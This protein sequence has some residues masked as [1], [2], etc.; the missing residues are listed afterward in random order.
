MT[1]LRVTAVLSGGGVKAAA[2]LGAVRALVE[3]GLSP[4]RYIG[5]SMGAVMAAALAAG[6]EPAGIFET[7]AGLR[8]RDLARLSAGALVRGV[9]AE[10]LLHPEPL[11]RALEMLVPA[12][13][14][15]ELIH[16]LTV[17]AVD[18]DSGL[19]VRFGAGGEE[20]LLHDALYAAC[21]LP[22]WYPPRVLGGRRLADGGLRGPLPLEVAG[23]FPADLLVAV[24][25]GPGTDAVP[26][27]GR[28]APPPLLR[29]HGEATG[30]L[31]ARTT[32]LEVALWR[33]TPNR[34]ELIYLRPVAERGATFAVREIT[35]Y[36]KAGYESTM[37]ALAERQKA[38]A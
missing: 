12:R 4:T 2:H 29:I 32:E 9:F 13:H 15:G 21:A 30:A 1:P 7:A 17:T 8:R 34:P 37:A 26:R 35:R 6:R 36:E 33:A 23:E 16:P 19:L 25:A 31:M 27:T 18:L 28:M 22:L 3:F 38:R 24:D 5:T 20:A 11:E 10:A 14:F